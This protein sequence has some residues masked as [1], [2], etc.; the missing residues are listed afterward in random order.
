MRPLLHLPVVLKRSK[1]KSF[2]WERYNWSRMATTEEG[3]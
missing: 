1:V 2:L 3:G